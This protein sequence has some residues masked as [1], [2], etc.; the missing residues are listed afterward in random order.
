MDLQKPNLIMRVHVGVV[1]LVVLSDGLSGGNDDNVTTALTLP[2]VGGNFVVGL[3]VTVE[4]LDYGSDAPGSHLFQAVETEH[5]GDVH[6][7]LPFGLDFTDSEHPLLSEILPLSGL[8]A[9][10]E[11]VRYLFGE[12]P[13]DKLHGLI[14]ELARGIPQHMLL[15]G[16]HV[17]KGEIYLLPP[18]RVI[19]VEIRDTVLYGCGVL[20]FAPHFASLSAP[21]FGANIYSFNHDLLMIANYGTD[22]GV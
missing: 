1:R 6:G 9:E 16:V 13:H 5:F 15:H 2:H 8:G 4:C 18:T 14:D 12:R 3:I 17:Q 21:Y 22:Q 20:G 10:G 7:L 11:T 19:R